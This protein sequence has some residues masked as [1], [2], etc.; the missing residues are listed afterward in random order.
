[1][2]IPLPENAKATMKRNPDVYDVM[3]AIYLRGDQF[4]REKEHMWLMGLGDWNELLFVL[5]AALGGNNRVSAE[6]R[7]MFRV[8]MVKGATKII[9]VHNHPSGI[10]YPSEKDKSF[11]KHTFEQGRLLGIEV[12]D[13]FIISEQGYF[14]FANNIRLTGG[15]P[16]RGLGWDYKME[17]E[18]ER[19]EKRVRKGRKR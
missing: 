2:I 18:K 14:N 3:R 7:D 10:V 12:I 8:P 1:M 15:T 5:L 13:H 19:Y 6:S 4:E 9:L 17:L 11:T 16:L